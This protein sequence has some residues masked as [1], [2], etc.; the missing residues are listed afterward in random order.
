[1]TKPA[2][3]IIQL[4]TPIVTRGIR[5]LDDI[6]PF[7]RKISE[8][9]HSLL[10]QGPASIECEFDEALSLPDTIRKAI[11]AEQSGANAIIIDCMGDPGIHACREVVSIPVLGR[12]RPQCM[13]PA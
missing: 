8:I 11:E 10:D 6:E 7:L 13:L 5:T 3:T 4:I 9:R 1:M 12:A 2:K